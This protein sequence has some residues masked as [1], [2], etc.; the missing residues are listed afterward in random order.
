MGNEKFD[1]KDMEKRDEKAVDEKW[2]RDPLGA[3]VWAFILIWAGV[4]LLIDNLGFI[5]RWQNLLENSLGNNAGELTAWVIILLGA[6]I[7]L[8]FEVF[9]RLAVPAYRRPVS[10]TVILAFIFIGIA[11]TNIYSG[12]A[13]WA[14]ILIAIGVLMLVRG[15][16]PR[17]E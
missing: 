8:L 12:L 15:F 10:G 17:R 13:V 11:L 9:V 14:L 5:S 7:I 2:R 3:A 16:V 4:V 1:E 6:G